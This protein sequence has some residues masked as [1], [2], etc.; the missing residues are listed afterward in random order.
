MARSAYQKLPVR[1]N[2]IYDNPKTGKLEYWF[3]FKDRKAKIGEC[4]KD[5]PQGVID[6]WERGVVE[7]V[8]ALL[9]KT[10]GPNAVGILKGK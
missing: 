6:E 10:F 9:V 7:Q 5:L 3:V 2:G 1:K 8:Q 4:K